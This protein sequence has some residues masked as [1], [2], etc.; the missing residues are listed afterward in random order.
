ME[1]VCCTQISMINRRKVREKTRAA[2]VQSWDEQDFIVAGKKNLE[3]FVE[4]D[5]WKAGGMPSIWAMLDL[6]KK[7]G[8]VWI[9]MEQYILNIFLR[10]PMHFHV[11][12]IIAVD[13]PSKEKLC[14]IFATTPPAL[15][16]AN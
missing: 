9:C 14:V 10:G 4:S 2:G 8:Q 5:E 11:K 15:T 1:M 3:C 12:A 7:Q 6:A 13:V 16:R